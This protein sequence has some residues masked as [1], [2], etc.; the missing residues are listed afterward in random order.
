MTT[1][2]QIMDLARAME[3]RRIRTGR[4]YGPHAL[5]LLRMLHEFHQQAVAEPLVMTH[6]GGDL[7]AKEQTNVRAALAFLRLRCG[8]WQPLSKILKFKQTTLGQIQGGGKPVSPTLGVPLG[9]VRPRDR[10]RRSDGALSGA[11]NLPALRAHEGS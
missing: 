10:G 7:T 5:R 4:L 9:S 2:I 1:W 11:W 3:E 6:E 8:G